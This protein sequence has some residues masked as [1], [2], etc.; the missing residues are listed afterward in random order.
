MDDNTTHPNAYR[1]EAEEKRRQA[2]LLASEA[3]ALIEK[4]ELL[5]HPDKD[6][7]DSKVAAKASAEANPGEA[8]QPSQD[9]KKL[10]HK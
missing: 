9:K 8:D 4:A 6:V 10:F 1:L 3:N 5:E 7:H 2:A